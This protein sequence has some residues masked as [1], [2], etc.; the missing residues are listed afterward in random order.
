MGTTFYI[1]STVKMETFWD[2]E[3]GDEVGGHG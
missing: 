1:T 3:V 2:D